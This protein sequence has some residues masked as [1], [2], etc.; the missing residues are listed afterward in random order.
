MSKRIRVGDRGGEWGIFVAKPGFDVETCDKADL[1]FYSGG[2]TSQVLAQG[3]VSFAANTTGAVS[4]P[5]SN[6]NGFTPIIIVYETLSVPTG[7]AATMNSEYLVYSCN[8]TT[9]SITLPWQLVLPVTSSYI[10]FT[11]STNG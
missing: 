3:S 4:I 2:R 7:T 11:D 9:L 1:M 5:L 6:T 10:V 8:S